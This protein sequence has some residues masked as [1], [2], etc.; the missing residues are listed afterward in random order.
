LKRIQEDG[1]TV[2]LS[3]KKNKV[4]GLKQ[5]KTAMKVRCFLGPSGGAS[6]AVDSNNCK[7]IKI[8]SLYYDSKYGQIHINPLHFEVRGKAID[9]QIKH[10]KVLYSSGDVKFNIIS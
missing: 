6:Y 10:V 4:K 1:I 8:R 3:D 2:E 7:I 5:E 9:F